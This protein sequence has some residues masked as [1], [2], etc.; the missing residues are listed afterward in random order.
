MIRIEG[1][2]EG[3][4]DICILCQTCQTTP[5][6]LPKY[7]LAPELVRAVI[8]MKIGHQCSVSHGERASSHSCAQLF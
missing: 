2:F 8:V 4:T 1:P 6:V 7:P 5:V 3:N